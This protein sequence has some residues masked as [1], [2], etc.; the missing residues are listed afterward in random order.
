MGVAARQRPLEQLQQQQQQQGGL[1]QENKVRTLAAIRRDRLR[2]QMARERSQRRE[3][4]QRPQQGDCAGR[5]SFCPRFVEGELRLNYIGGVLF[6][7]VHKKPKEGRIPADVGA[8]SI[9]T[10]Y[11]PDDDRFADLAKNFLTPPAMPAL[12]LAEGPIPVWWAIDFV[13]ASAVGTPMGEEEW[14]VGKCSCSCVGVPKRLATQDVPVPMMQEEIVHVPRIILQE[15][16]TQ[17]H[18]EMVGGLP[19]PMTQG[20]TVHVPTNIL[21]ERITQRHIELVAEVPVPMI[22]EE[23]AHAPVIIP[24]ERIQQQ[25][26]EI[27]VEVPVPMTPE[28]IVHMPAIIP[29]E[30]IVHVPIII[31]QERIQRPHVVPVEVP[32]PMTREEIVHVP[33][34]IAQE[35][36]QQQH[37]ERPV[38]VPM[39]QEQIANPPIIIPQERIQQQHVEKPVEVPGPMTQEEIGHVPIIIPQ[40]RIR[41]QHVEIPVEV[42]IPMMQEEI[43]HVPIIIPQER[44]QQ[45]HGGI[46]VEVHAPMT[47]EKIVHMPT[48]IPQEHIRQQHVEIPVEVHAPMTQE[49]IVHVPIIPQER[50]QRQHVEPPVEVPIP[51]TQEEIVHV[52]IITAQERIQQQHVEMPVEVPVPMTQKEIVHAPIIPQERIQQQH[53]EKP[54]EV[55]GPMT[56]EEIGHEFVINDAIG[57]HPKALLN[58]DTIDADAKAL[59][60]A[61]MK[62][63]SSPK[64]FYTQK[65]VEGVATLACSV[66]PKKIIVRLSDFKSNEYKSLIGGEQYEPDEENPMIGF[67]GC[68]RYTDPFFEECFA[69]ELEAIKKV[70]GEMGLTNVEILVPFARTLDM[71]KDVM[72]VLKKNGLESGKDGLTVHMVAELPSIVFLADEFPDIF[73][74]LSIGSNDLTQ[75]TLGLDL[76]SGLVAQYSVIPQGRIQRQHVEIPVEVPVPMTQEETVHAFY[77]FWQGGDFIKNVEPQGDQAFCRMNEGFPEVGKAM[78]AAIKKTGNSRLLSA[79]ITASDPTEM[80]TRGRYIMSQFGPLTEDYTFLSLGG[81]API[82]GGRRPKADYGYLATAAHFS[83]ESIDALVYYVDPENGECKVSHPNLLFGRAIADGRDMMYSA[84]AHGGGNQGTDDAECDMIFGIHF[85]LEFLRLF[86]GSSC[87]V[88]AIGRILGRGTSSAGL[89]V[90]KIIKPKL[91]P[92]LEPS[93]EAYYSFWQGGDFVR[94]D[95]PW[96]LNECIPEVAK[97]MRAAIKVTDPGRE[98]FARAD[99]LRLELVRRK[100]QRA[101]STHLPRGG[102]GS[103][104]PACAHHHHPLLLHGEARDGEG[105]PPA[106]PCVPSVPRSSWRPS[107]PGR[108]GKTGLPGGGGQAGLRARV[109]GGRGR[110]ERGAHEAGRR[111][112]VPP[113]GRVGLHQER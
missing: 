68:G 82:R 75:L 24:Q 53:V 36:I 26:G 51:M 96:P 30:E 93:G 38:E 23:L 74:G 32:I 16:V 18:V 14:I 102:G 3:Q 25:H 22:Q 10:S 103:L 92:Q 94:N 11:G 4:Q 50:I 61:K 99:R 56:Q 95:A 19:V 81:D 57:V 52:P 46:P 33:I 80:I 47:Q 35:R 44:I 54:V 90:G 59:I 112:P 69:M 31:P 29:Q 91:G 34:I 15:R 101:A 107:V 86:D 12:G 6:S 28:E 72:E 41:Q 89:V 113:S 78:R 98:A 79:N 63:Y 40:E 62:G 45:Q 70:R 17:Q 71:A 27:P 88:S 77:S 43:V 73:D 110:D 84:L 42:P 39:I 97:A 20:G 55:P 2:R 65:I 49:E 109:P 108:P 7:I 1:T 13:L 64:E 111:G 58:Y 85:P 105:P 100:A 60:D 21:Q 48:I 83:A 104:G 106:T 8:G 67:R 37:L 66:Y 5:R 9:Y 76:D 87:S